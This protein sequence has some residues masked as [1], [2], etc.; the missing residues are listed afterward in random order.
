MSPQFRVNS[1]HIPSCSSALCSVAAW[2]KSPLHPPSQISPINADKPQAELVDDPHTSRVAFVI[3]GL[4]HGFRL[5]FNPHLVTLNSSSTN[6][7]SAFLQPAVI[8][9]YLQNELDK[10]RV[11]GPFVHPP[12]PNLHVSRFGV[13]P[14]KHQPGKWHLILDLSSPPDASVNDGIPRDSYSFHYI[15]VGDIIDGIMW[16]GRGTLMAKFDVESAYRNV[17]INPENHFLLGMQWRGWYFVDMA[18]P[19]GLRSAPSIFNS[20]ADLLEW[21]LVHNRKV[22]FLRHYLDDFHTLGAA[23]SPQCH[24]NLAACLEAFADWGM[25]LHPDKLEGPSTRLSVLGTELDSVTLQARSPQEKFDRIIWLLVEWS[26][27]RY[28]QRKDLESLIGHLHHVCKVVPQGHTFLCCMI[29][30]LSAFQRD[31][32]PI[33]LNNAFHL[34]LNWWRGFFWSWSGLSF[35]LSLQW[36][37]LP[38]FQVSSDAAGTSGYGAT[39]GRAWL[40][41]T[42]SSLQMP[43][44]ISYKELFPGV[45][46]ASLWGHQW[47]SKRVEF[48][49]ENRAVVA[50]LQSGT[51]R[52]RN[53]GGLA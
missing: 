15:T 4:R 44:S 49:S 43:L 14:K 41:G 26:A 51:S 23:N 8:D 2:T 47:S 13:I 30:L 12:W 39:F 37:P 40:A 32:H 25:P 33:R 22:Q 24:Q 27:K 18:L 52:D 3:S 38:D 53:L 7:P 16:Y 34:D 9:E 19:F 35:F 45:V 31:D 48:C 28:C 29:N 5:G 10:G 6:M 46:A 17:A 42:W 1:V 11:A 50:M 21:I 36:A 20:I